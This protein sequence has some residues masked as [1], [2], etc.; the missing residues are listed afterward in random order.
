[1]NQRAWR[2]CGGHTLPRRVFMDENCTGG[3][4]GASPLI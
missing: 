3:K 1:M 4:S 2:K